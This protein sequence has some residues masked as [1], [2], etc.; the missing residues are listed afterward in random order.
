LGALIVPG[1]G[2]RLGWRSTPL[3]IEIA[4][5][6]LTNAGTVVVFVV[7]LQNAYASKLLDINKDQVLIDTGLYAH[8]RHPMYAGYTL[9]ILTVPVALGSWWGLIP[10]VVGVLALVVRIGFE[11]EMLVQGMEGYEAYRA[12]VRYRLIPWIY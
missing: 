4:G 1:V 7:M 3:A 10:A 11:E 6:V 8:V 9:M 5:L 12:R 2:H